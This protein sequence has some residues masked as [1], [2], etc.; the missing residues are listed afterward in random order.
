VHE[1]VHSRDDKGWAP[2]KQGVGDGKDKASSM[3]EYV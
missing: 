2:E 1:V 3:A